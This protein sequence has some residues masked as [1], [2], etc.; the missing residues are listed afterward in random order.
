MTTE[1]WDSSHAYEQYVGRWSRKVATEFLRWLAPLP[2]VKWADVGCG[3]GALSSAILDI[4][5]PSLVFGIDSSEG[6][7]SQARQN[8]RDPRVQFETGVRPTCLGMRLPGT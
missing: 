3:T 8:I 7:V 6:F 4:C 1:A 2:N 5:E